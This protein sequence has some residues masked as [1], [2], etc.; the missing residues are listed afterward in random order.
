MMSL[1][2]YIEYPCERDGALQSVCPLNGCCKEESASYCTKYH[3]NL[4]MSHQPVGVWSVHP[5]FHENKNRKISSEESGR[6]S[7]NICTSENSRYMVHRC[8]CCENEILYGRHI[9]TLCQIAQMPQSYTHFITQLK[10]KKKR[11]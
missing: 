7:A 2:A 8:V 9:Q 5:T 3:P 10:K 11:Y 6:F 1:R 4:K